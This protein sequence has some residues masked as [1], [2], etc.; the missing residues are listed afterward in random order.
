MFDQEKI[1]DIL[2][3]VYVVV[4]LGYLYGL[5]IAD[6]TISRIVTRIWGML[7]SRAIEPG[8]PSIHN[9]FIIYPWQVSLVGISER[10]LFIVSL[11]FGRPEFIAIWLT[12]KTIARSV[13]WTKAKSVPGRAIYNTFLIGTALSIGFSFVAYSGMQWAL[14]T[15]SDWDQN[16]ALALVVPIAFWALVFSF[17]LRLIRLAKREIPPDEM[18]KLVPDD[19]QGEDNSPP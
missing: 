13:R 4:P 18:S 16:L 14:G 15:D 8:S 11:Q 7:K 3:S 5:F 6:W 19:E 17:D 10:F 1:L 12:L 2:T 9:E